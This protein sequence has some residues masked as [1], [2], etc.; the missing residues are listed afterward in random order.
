M[1]H[2]WDTRIKSKSMTFL[3]TVISIVKEEINIETQTSTMADHFPMEI[4]NHL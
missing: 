2:Q 1:R 3:S 4:P